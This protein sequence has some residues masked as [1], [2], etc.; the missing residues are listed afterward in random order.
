M[1]MM[2]STCSD[3]SDVENLQR[4]G[5]AKC[6][7]KLALHVV[8]GRKVK[9]LEELRRDGDAASSADVSESQILIHAVV[10]MLMSCCTASVSV[11]YKNVNPW[12]QHMFRLLTQLT[13][14]SVPGG[15]VLLQISVVVA[16]SVRV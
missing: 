12:L 6:L 1:M 8:L 16:H 11:T 13:I 9:L 7:S 5:I 10:Q 2:M 15:E 4:S 3:T 14:W